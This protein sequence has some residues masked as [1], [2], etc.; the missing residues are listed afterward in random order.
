MGIPNRNSFLQG[1]I[2][3]LA[4][5]IPYMVRRAE[6]RIPLCVSVLLSV[7]LSFV[8]VPFIKGTAGGRVDDGWAEDGL[9]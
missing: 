1:K 9:E 7:Q 3:Q 2:V 5:C 6:Q 8:S 4:P